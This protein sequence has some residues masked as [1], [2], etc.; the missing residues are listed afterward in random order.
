[1]TMYFKNRAKARKF[2]AKADKYKVADKGT[3]APAKRRWGVVV[4]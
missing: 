1:M 4:A 3:Y 2:A